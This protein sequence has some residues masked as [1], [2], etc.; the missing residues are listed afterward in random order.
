MGRLIID[1]NKVYEIDEKCL[2]KKRRK[3]AQQKREERT[4]KHGRFFQQNTDKSNY[5]E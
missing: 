5:R 1:G 3:E 2:E 4:Q